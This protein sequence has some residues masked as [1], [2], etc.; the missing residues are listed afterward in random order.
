MVTENGKISEVTKAAERRV[1][2]PNTSVD[3]THFK[4]IESFQPQRAQRF[5]EENT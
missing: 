2:I 1:T 3:G 5:T 4:R